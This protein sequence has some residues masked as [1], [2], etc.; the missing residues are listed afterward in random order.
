MSQALPG[1]LTRYRRTPDFTAATVPSALLADHA[2]KPGVWAEIVVTDGVLRLTRQGSG[3]ADEIGPGAAGVL[4]PEEV[5][6]V[7]PAEDV[8]FHICFWR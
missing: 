5:H 6:F 2:T 1:G 8:V 4:A 3:E 7:T